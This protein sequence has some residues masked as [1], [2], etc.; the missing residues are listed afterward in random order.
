MGDHAFTASLLRASSKGFAGLVA[1]QMF[2]TEPST[3]QTAG[4]DAWQAHANRQVLALASAVEDEAPELFSAAVAWSRD[5]FVGRRV[6]PDGLALS[7]KCLEGVLEESLPRHAWAILPEYFLRAREALEDGGTHASPEVERVGALF[8][9]SQRYLDTLVAGDEQ[10][11]VDLIREALDTDQLS[12]HALIDAVLVP[13]QRELGRRWHVGELSV[14]DEHLATQ[15]TRKVLALALAKAP[16]VRQRQRTVIVA[17]LA[18]DTHDIALAFVAAHFELDG[19]RTLFLGADT[20]T[21]DLVSFVVRHQADLVALGATL[22]EQR[23]KIA[24]TVRALREA[25]PALRIVVGGAAYA[26]RQDLWLR[27]GADAYAVDAA[28]AVKKG[29]ELVGA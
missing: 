17:A 14:S 28:A 26:S 25:R 2:E 7:L 18:G 10:R 21:D 15:A 3:V 27:S 19:W 13:A 4:F 20:P 9:L 11:A 23:A 24:D 16:R 29:L 6:S 22:D 12:V 8:D 1:T 5:A